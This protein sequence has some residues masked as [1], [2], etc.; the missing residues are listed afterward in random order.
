MRGRVPERYRVNRLI[1]VPQLRV[2]GAE[3]EA[4]G[5]ISLE[6][7]IRAA[8]EAGLDLVEVA[9]TSD[10]P[11]AKIMDYGKFKYQMG[12]RERETRKKQKGITIKEVKMGP[13]VGD[14]D[15]FFKRDHGIAFLKEGHKLKVTIKFRGRE[16]THTE[17]GRDILMRM[18]EELADYGKV[19][20]A[21]KLEGRN[22]T[23][24]ICPKAQ[25]AS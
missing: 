1:R 5:I 17:L 14:H 23:M 11:V 25:A 8:D 3:G 21:P 10:P 24:M 16:M 2:I 18:Q 22:M 9:P 19:E 12:K 15:F 20:M 13:K 7:A 4:L 6:D